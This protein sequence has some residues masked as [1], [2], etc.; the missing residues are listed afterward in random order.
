MGLSSVD[1]SYEEV[2]VASGFHVSSVK[3]RNS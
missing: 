2:G 1:S 3:P